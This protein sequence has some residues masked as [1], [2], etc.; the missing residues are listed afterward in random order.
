MFR[1]PRP[2]SL[3]LNLAPMV[4]VMMCLII[5]FLLASKIVDAEHR[6]VDLPYAVAARII[7]RAEL[8]AHLVINV[9]RNAETGAAEYVVVGWDGKNLIE[10]LLAVDDLQPHMLA[11]LAGS[12]VRPEDFHCIVRADRELAYRDIEL[13]LRACG[14]A[15]IGHVVF[16]ANAAEAPGGAP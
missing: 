9:R 14:L 15:K 7:D 1:P 5:F 11:K 2:V 16:S 10:K 4:D 6:P 3:I 12:G 8:G 13:V